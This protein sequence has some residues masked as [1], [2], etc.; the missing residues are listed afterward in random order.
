MC[1]VYETNIHD[2]HLPLCQEIEITQISLIATFVADDA[3]TPRFHQLHT[4]GFQLHLTSNSK[5]TLSM[6]DFILWNF[7]NLHNI[8]RSLQVVNPR[9][10]VTTSIQRMRNAEYTGSQTIKRCRCLPSRVMIRTIQQGLNR[11]IRCA[12]CCTP[13]SHIYPR[14][15]YVRLCITTHHVEDILIFPF[16]DEGFTTCAKLFFQT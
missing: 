13:P 12:K 14:H 10:H 11:V 5:Q 4:G 2:T 6:S 1:R 7:F 3:S 8:I 16:L 9:G 15:F